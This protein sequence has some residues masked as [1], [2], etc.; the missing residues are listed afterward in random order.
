MQLPE[1]QTIH[2]HTF[3]FSDDGG[4]IEMRLSWRTEPIKEESFLGQDEVL[5][6]IENHFF[7]DLNE[8]YDEEEAME[9]ELEIR[10]LFEDEEEEI[11][12]RTW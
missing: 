6:W 8:I 3:E 7:V 2:D 10:T 4:W 1:F 12:A 11:G 9:V 5:A